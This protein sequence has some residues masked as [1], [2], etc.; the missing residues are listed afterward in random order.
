MKER[1]SKSVGVEGKLFWIQSF[2]GNRTYKSWSA[3][4][5]S[6]AKRVNRGE[7]GNGNKV[8]EKQ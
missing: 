1:Q 2:R 6:F 3:E 5:R 4:H 8:E 7:L